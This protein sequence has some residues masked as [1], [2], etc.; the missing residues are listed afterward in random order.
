TVNVSGDLVFGLASDHGGNIRVNNG[1]TLNVTGSLLE[2]TPTVNTAQLYLNGGT[3]NVGGD[4]SAQSFRTADSAGS[5]ASY[6]QPAGQTITSTGTLFAGN[7]GV[8]THTVD[9][10]TLLVDNSIRIAEQAGG[11]GSSL[12]LD[13][14]SVHNRGGN[15]TGNTNKQL[16]IGRRGD[17]TVVVNGGTFTND[18]TLRFGQ[19]A[20][21]DSAL[22]INGGTFVQNGNITTG[23]GT[24]TIAVAGGTL[25]LADNANQR[26]VTTLTQSDGEV[27]FRV[28]DTTAGPQ[29]LAATSVTFTGGTITPTPDLAPSVDDGS[30]ASYTGPGGSVAAPVSGAWDDDLNWETSTGSQLRPGIGG[31]T[32]EG[33]SSFTLITYGTLTGTPTSGDPQWAVADDSAGN[34]S[35]TY[36]GP[37]VGSAMPATVAGTGVT[38]TRDSQ[39]R[40]APNTFGVDA[41]E[42]TVDAATLELTG[43]SGLDIGGAG[44]VDATVTLQNGATATV[45]GDVTFGPSGAQRGGTLNINGGSTLNVGGNIVET[46][47]SIP[48]AQLHINN[49]TLDMSNNGSI[50]VQRFSVAEVAGSD[51][52]YT[53]Q[54]DITST[55][56]FNVAAAGN[57]TGS[58][59]VDDPSHTITAANLSVAQ[60]LANDGSDTSNGSFNLIAG[61]LDVNSGNLNIAG[62][63]QADTSVSA[64]FTQ[65][66]GT[67]NPAVTV[68]GGNSE[69]GHGGTAIIQIKSGTYTQNT[70]NIVIAQGA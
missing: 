46:A 44:T 51:A 37:T 20:A 26:S 24:S 43:N 2:R 61:A 28:R 59:T 50:V 27:I 25:D 22:T 40:I 23:T 67:T 17:A 66:D 12:I 29:P 45:P 63:S 14:G 38:V 65:G 33:G 68:S 41:T 11:A 48:N 32:L 56:T 15:N 36:N 30:S 21:T 16:D 39:L 64:N 58:F 10:G 55:G 62:D 52:S 35:A 31:G 47:T 54:G 6:S 57:A 13:S 69:W 60:G 42:L 7:N 70:N 8:G 1:G 34:I 9:G 4:I 19:G 3:L 5:V 18:A 49:G 53:A